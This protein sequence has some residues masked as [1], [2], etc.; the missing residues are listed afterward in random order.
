MWHELECLG[1]PLDGV[2]I[3]YRGRMIAYA[4]KIAG[5]EHMYVVRPTDFGTM[6]VYQ[7]ARPVEV[8]A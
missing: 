8:A 1:G 7:G 4:F 3:P 6:L 2:Y 5:V